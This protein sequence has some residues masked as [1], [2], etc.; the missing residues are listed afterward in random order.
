MI[1]AFLPLSDDVAAASWRVDFTIGENR[2]FVNGQVTETDAA[3]FIENGRTYVPVRYPGDSL[4]ASVQWDAETRTV[5][6][7]KDSV[8]VRLVIGSDTITVAGESQAM[9]VVPLIRNGRTFL[10]ARYVA[11]ALGYQVAWNPQERMVSI[12]P[13][14]SEALCLVPGDIL[15]TISE[16]ELTFTFE[17]PFFGEV[18]LLLRYRDHVGIYVGDGQVVE[19]TETSGVVVSALSSWVGRPGQVGLEILR[20]DMNDDVR[21]AAVEF[22]KAQVGEAYD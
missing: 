20:V 11:E 21:L 8:E 3:S 1:V 19:A 2:Y 18:T 4:G 14:P 7:T 13:T 6:L 22:A 12:Q 15:V 5:V 16:E 17:V 10:P 9:D